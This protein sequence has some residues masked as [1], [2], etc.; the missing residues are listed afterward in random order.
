MADGYAVKGVE[1]SATVTRYL[2]GE[3]S[4]KYAGLVIIA[5]D[6]NSGTATYDFQCRTPG[7]TTWDAINAYPADSETPATSGTTTETWTIDATGKEI[8]F[9][10]SAKSGSPR[11]TWTTRIG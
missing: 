2:L 8:A 6:L 7:A 1:T 5:F 3:V 10:V 4:P 11:F 9:N